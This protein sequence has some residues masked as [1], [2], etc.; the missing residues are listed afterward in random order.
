M[1]QI[2]IVDA[3]RTLSATFATYLEAQGASVGLA[4]S[5]QSAV[6]VCEEK[7][8]DIIILELQLVGHSGVE[9]LHELR[10]YAE[11]QHIP[12]LL[13][14][15]IPERDLTGFDEA[16]ETLGVVGYLYK[17]DTSLK[18]LHEKVQDMIAE[19]V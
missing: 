11:W 4:V 2:L 12:V 9:F 5:A 3:D 14:T 8:P 19:H 6:L 16:F 10:S 17:P 7:T 13:H 18:K 15:N 1:K